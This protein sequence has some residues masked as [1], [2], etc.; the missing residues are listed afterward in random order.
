M[1]CAGPLASQVSILIRK[2]DDCVGV[3]DVHPLGVV[4]GR[5]E[6]N[7]IR[8]VESGGEDAGLLGLALAR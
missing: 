6:R 1:C 3:A 2:P 5:I 8:L 7:A 4:S